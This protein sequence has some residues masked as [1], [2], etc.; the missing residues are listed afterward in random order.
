MRKS[1]L[2]LPLMLSVAALSVFLLACGG[3]D[4]DN[5][6]TNGSSAQPDVPPPAQALNLT[7]RAG[8][9]Y[10]EPNTWTVKAGQPVNVT[11]QSM[12]PEFPHTFAIRNLSGEGQLFQSE[13]YENGQTGNFTFTVAQPGTY[14]VLCTVRGHADRGQTGL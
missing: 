11:F 10:F 9:W 1:L 3:D 12:G 14:Q 4:D 6:A 2:F 8:D 13:R 7:I 5:G